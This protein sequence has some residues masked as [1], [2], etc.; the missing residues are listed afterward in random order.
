MSELG[1]A[2]R[3]ADP[4]VEIDRGP[5]RGGRCIEPVGI[6]DALAAYVEASEALRHGSDYLPAQEWEEMRVTYDDARADLPTCWPRS[7]GR[8]RDE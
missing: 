8:K 7:R 3:A 1:D 4:V 2:V 5:E 6:A